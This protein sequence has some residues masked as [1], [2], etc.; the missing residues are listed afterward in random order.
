MRTRSSRAI[1]TASVCVPAL[2]LTGL[3]LEEAAVVERA[4]AEEEAERRNGALTQ[5]RGVAQFLVRRE[6]GALAADDR[7]KQLPVDLPVSREYGE[8]EARLRLHEHRLRARAEFG[9]AHRSG[10]GARRHRVVMREPEI[11]ALAP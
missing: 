5:A 6:P 4:K 3:E 2:K 9:P 11:D 10:L 1:V 7:R 8:D